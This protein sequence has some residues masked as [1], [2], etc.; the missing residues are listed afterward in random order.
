MCVI[1]VVDEIVHVK[2]VEPCKDDEK[3]EK[4]ENEEEKKKDE[5]EEEKSEGKWT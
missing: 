3:E 2:P 1:F 5:K 4:K